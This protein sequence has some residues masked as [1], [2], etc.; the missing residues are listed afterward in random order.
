MLP[1]NFYRIIHKNAKCIKRNNIQQPDSQTIVRFINCK[2]VLILSYLI[3][4]Q[5]L[6]IIMFCIRQSEDKILTKLYDSEFV[7]TSVP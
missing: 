1:I 4:W 3:L 6:K 2:C 5:I 7:V